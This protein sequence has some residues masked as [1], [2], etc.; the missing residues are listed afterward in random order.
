MKINSYLSHNSDTLSNFCR[1][2]LIFFKN[3]I[4]ETGL[5]EK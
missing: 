1:K 5:Q 2:V 4:G 3:G